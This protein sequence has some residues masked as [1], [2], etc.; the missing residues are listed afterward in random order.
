[1]EASIPGKTNSYL[2]CI[3]GGRGREGGGGVR[4]S[5]PGNMAVSF[6]MPNRFPGNMALIWSQL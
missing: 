6:I 1:M 5:F 3:F 4:N 2:R